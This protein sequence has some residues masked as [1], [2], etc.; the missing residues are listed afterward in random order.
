MTKEG[1]LVTSLIPVVSLAPAVA[2]T[3]SVVAG[4]LLYVIIDIGALEHLRQ[5]H[6]HP[7]KYLS[8]LGICVDVLVVASSNGRGTRHQLSEHEYKQNEDENRDE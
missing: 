4:A 7:I 5:V 2:V 6:R 3:V 1:Y 8:R